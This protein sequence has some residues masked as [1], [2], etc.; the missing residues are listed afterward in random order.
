M[1]HQYRYQAGIG[2]VGSY[3]VSGVPY[4]TGS[5][6]SLAPLAEDKIEFPSIT[7]TITVIN[8]DVGGCDIHAHFNSKLLGNVSGG[9]HYI[10]LTSVNDAIT[11]NVKSKEIFI[12]NPDA[13]EDASYTVVAELTG[14]NVSEM[15]VLTGS[16]L[17][18]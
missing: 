3:Q 18:D 5:V 13:V 4:L 12:S 10:A 9:L 11:F 16:G 6:N 14:I 2:D 8:T 17:T 15:F 1:S 7:R